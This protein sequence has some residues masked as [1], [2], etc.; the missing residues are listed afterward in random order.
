MPTLATALPNFFLVGAPK[1][2]TTSLYHYLDQHPQV[3]MSPMKEPCYFASE[4]RPANFSDEL[5][6]WISR[7]VLA[8]QQYL[9]GPMQEK[10]FA[11][12]I[13]EWDDYVRLF[14]NVREETAIGEASVCYLWS[15]S[16]ARNIAARM[17]GAKILMIL[18]NPVDRAFSQ[19]LHAATCG[20]V[21]RSFP[22]QI[23]GA[24]ASSDGR[25]ERVYPFL[26]FGM[27]AG[28]VKRYLD[29]FPRENVR[30]HLYEDYQKRPA[31][32]LADIFRFLQVD[33]S[34]TPDRSVRS[35]EPRVPKFAA[36]TYF[37]KKYGIW[38]RAGELSPRLLRPL[39]RTM[40]FRRR[41][42]LAMARNDREYL[43]DYYRE[44]VRKLSQLL[45]RDLPGWLH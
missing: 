25:F 13:L 20:A 34:F 6:P 21:V 26:E 5:Q 39:L 42:S 31:Q 17:P 3:Y 24:P 12:L 37:L 10:R 4:L 14:Q 40:A 1:A 35:L 16:A 15:E 22:A 27:Y 43:I 28:Q 36:V 44:D 18:R 7:T 29:L 23:R 19:Y 38:D 41:Q 8:A 30:I 9:D 11:G 33:S 32:M 45:G 2:G